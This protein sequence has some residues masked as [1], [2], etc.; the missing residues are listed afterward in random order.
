MPTLVDALSKL[1]KLFR[2]QF[3]LQL[4]LDR[5]I[6]EVSTAHQD[7]FSQKYMQQI[8]QKRHEVREYLESNLL[9]YPPQH[10]KNHSEELRKF[11]EVAPYDKSVFIMTK[12]AETD[13]GDDKVLKEIIAEV[14][15]SIIGAGFI[16]RIAT[17][18]YHDWLWQNVELYLLGCEKGVAIVE[19]RCRKEMNPNVAFEWGWMKGMGKRVF[20][21]MEESFAHNRADWSGLLSKTFSW[22]NPKEGIR[23][24]LREWLTIKENPLQ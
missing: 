10:Y 3:E 4:E 23:E 12:F 1:A 13:E 9:R 17:F 18:G 14:K 19:D 2:E 11:L 16:P 22:D 7:E 24:A 5:L 21:L 8:I 20:Y 15:S 6:D